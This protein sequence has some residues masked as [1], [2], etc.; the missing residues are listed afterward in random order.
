M[1]FLGGK[2]AGFGNTPMNPPT[3]SQSEL[4][5]TTLTSLTSGWSLLSLGA[6]KVKENAFKYGSYASQK[7]SIFLPSIFIYYFIIFF[8]SKK[9]YEVSQNVTEKVFI[10]ICH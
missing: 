8:T 6:N 2:Y 3:R 1:F 5:D 9:V 4:F 7:V 10:I